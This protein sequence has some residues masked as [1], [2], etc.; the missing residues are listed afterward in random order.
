VPASTTPTTP[1]PEHWPAIYQPSKTLGRSRH[2]TVLASPDSVRELADFYAAELDRG[3]WI[4]TCRVVTA[5]SAT[6]VARHG[7]HGAT[8]SISDTGTRCA[9]SIGSY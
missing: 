7:P 6:L 3:G 2:L 1:L 8:I 4:T 9:V 5:A